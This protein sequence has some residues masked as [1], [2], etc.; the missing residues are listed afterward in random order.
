ME[1]HA[2]EKKEPLAPKSFANGVEGK[3][4]PAPGVA[5]CDEL[6]PMEKTGIIVELLV[7]VEEERELEV[8]APEYVTNMI[9][10]VAAVLV[11]DIAFTKNYSGIE[12]NW[13]RR[14]WGC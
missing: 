10:V 14:V 9:I 3:V 5:M 6:L 12:P 13:S 8:D 7:A 2:L 1:K 11:I 4:A